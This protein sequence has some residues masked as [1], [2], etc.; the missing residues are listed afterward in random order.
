M[1]KKKKI[2]FMTGTRADYSKVHPIIC[3][4][5][6]FREFETHIFVTGMHLLER[7]GETIREVLLDHER[8]FMFNN[9]SVPFRMDKSLANTIQGFSDYISEIQPDMIVVHG[10]RIEPLAGA[11]V[12]A[13]NNVLTCHVEG[14]EISG[15]VDEVIRH[16]ISKL[17]H[18]HLVA[19]EAASQRLRRMGESEHSIFVVGS[20]D[21]DLM[22]SDEL[23]SLGQVLEHYEIPFREYGIA[24]CHP[25]TTELDEVKTLAENFVDA[26][27]ESGLNYIV[28]HPNND[29]GSDTIRHELS[30]LTAYSSRV[31]QYPSIRFSRF[32]TLL[33][34]STFVVGNSSLGIREAPVYGVP[35]LNIGSRQN[36]RS[37]GE[38]IVNV[39]LGKTEILAAI[40]QVVALPKSPNRACFEFGDGQSVKRIVQIF[41]E[42]AIWHTSKQ[43]VFS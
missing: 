10:D 3:G 4:L 27:I 26:L 7:H 23:P 36:G 9:Q 21:I 15:T 14:G 32:L 12:G 2:V 37:S 11:I 18:I 35:S 16:A 5:D 28:V 41:R 22:L 39:G 24:V 19:N 20:P 40:R 8:I 34:H 29:H 1:D 17:S 38:T 30:R 33:K 25:V 13:T 31:V 6:Y 43:K 42:S